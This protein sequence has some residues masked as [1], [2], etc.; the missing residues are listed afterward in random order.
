MGA[1]KYQNLQIMRFL[2]RNR[3]ADRRLGLQD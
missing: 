2:K 1:K 3:T